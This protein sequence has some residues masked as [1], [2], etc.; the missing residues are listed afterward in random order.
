MD[1]K[2]MKPINKL[3]ANTKN[4]IVCSVN[5]QGYPNS[6]AMFKIAHDG[7]KVFYFSTNTSSMRT[8]QFLQ[9]PKASLYF[10]GKIK[11]HGLMLVGEMAVLTDDETKQRFWQP[12]WRIYYPK[13]VTDPDY[14]ILK[15][16]AQSGNYYHAL[17]KHIFDID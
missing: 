1:Q 13:G 11:T 3:I 15:F 8:G 2:I 6:K 10:C 7:L 14:C 16:T 9:N 17:Q 12:F 4:I 5:K